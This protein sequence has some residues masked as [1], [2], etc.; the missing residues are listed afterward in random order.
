MVIVPYVEHEDYK[1][2]ESLTDDRSHIFVPADENNVLRE[3]K[4]YDR[5][6]QYNSRCSPSSKI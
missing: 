6:I 4:Q 3:G 1:F 5:G 2:K